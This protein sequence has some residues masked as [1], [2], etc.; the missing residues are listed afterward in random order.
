MNPEYLDITKMESILISLGTLGVILVAAI[1]FMAIFIGMAP[2]VSLTFTLFL[3]G[4]GLTLGLLVNEAKKEY[5]TPKVYEIEGKISLSQVKKYKISELKNIED[6]FFFQKNSEGYIEIPE[7]IQF[8]Y[9][10][11]KI[12]EKYV[13]KAKNYPQSF[14]EKSSNRITLS[15]KYLL[16]KFF[17]VP[18]FKTKPINKT[19]IFPYKT[20]YLKDCKK[21]KNHVKKIS[22]GE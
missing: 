4:V 7:S 9:K 19:K 14:F 20:Y 3:A 16:H 1:T 8:T 5:L 21:L 11:D 12:T 13:I 15:G 17:L 10:C 6:G 2:M 18:S 22:L